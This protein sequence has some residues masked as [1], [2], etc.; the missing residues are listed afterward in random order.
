[1]NILDAAPGVEL[2]A[3]GDLFPEP[4]EA[5]FGQL[6]RTR[7]DSLMAKMGSTVNVTR[8]RCFSGCDAYQNECR[9]GRALKWNWAMNA[10][11]SIILPPR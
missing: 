1:M 4:L 7:P 2:Y 11:A 6:S 5:A 8:E 9:T 10:S 3:L